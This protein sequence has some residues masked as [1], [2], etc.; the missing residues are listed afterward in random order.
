[1]YTLSTAVA[2]HISSKERQE[3]NEAMERRAAM[4]D[5]AFRKE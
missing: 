2:R 1:M 3:F 5:A 4:I